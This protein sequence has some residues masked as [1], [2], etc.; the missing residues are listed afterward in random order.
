MSVSSGVAAETRVAGIA[1]VAGVARVAGVAGVAGVTTV[2]GAVAQLAH[3]GRGCIRKVVWLIYYIYTCTTYR[4]IK[5][6]LLS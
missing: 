3:H 1:G 4:S 2:D 5:C 6:I